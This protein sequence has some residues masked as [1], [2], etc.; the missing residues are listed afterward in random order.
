MNAVTTVPSA[1]ATAGGTGTGA[2]VGSGTPVTSHPD[3]TSTSRMPQLHQ[4][5]LTKHLVRAQ[6]C[7]PKGVLTPDT[8]E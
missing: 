8:I 7:H 5:P 6:I 3:P 1:A 2:P 4:A